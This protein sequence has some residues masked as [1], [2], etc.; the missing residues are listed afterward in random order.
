MP[1][2]NLTSVSIRPF[3]GPTYLNSHT[4]PQYHVQ[5]GQF[6]TQSRAI[7]WTTLE[8]MKLIIKFSNFD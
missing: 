7:L 3:K 4:G 6:Y 8:W 1:F 2:C 5:W